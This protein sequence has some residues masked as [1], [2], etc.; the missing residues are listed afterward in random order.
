MLSCP[1]FCCWG[2]HKASWGK[3]HL[4]IF[5]YLTNVEFSLCLFFLQNEYVPPDWLS[6]LEVVVN[7]IA[8][9]EKNESS[10]LF[11]LLGTAVEAGQNIISA[12]IPMLISSV[13]GAIVNHIPPIPDPWPQVVC[14]LNLALFRF[15]ISIMSIV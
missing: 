3:N 13:V 5:V 8:N 4:L 10:F 2:H 14:W 11:H 7:Q 6:V 12:H 1:C 15:V 9:G